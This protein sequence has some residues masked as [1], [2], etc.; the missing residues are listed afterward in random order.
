MLLKPLGV[1]TLA[2]LLKKLPV[3]GS[4][5]WDQSGLALSGFRVTVVLGSNLNN[6]AVEFISG[7]MPPYFV[8]IAFSA[9]A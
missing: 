3:S 7:E 6:P 9:F 5:V 1:E 8:N 4:L 2:C